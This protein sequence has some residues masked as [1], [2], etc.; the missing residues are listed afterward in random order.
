M[1]CRHRNLP[2][3]WATAPPARARARIEVFILNVGLLVRWVMDRKERQEAIEVN[4]G[5]VER[6]K[7]ERE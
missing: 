6:M 4:E 7:S 2:V 5:T 1:Q 3:V